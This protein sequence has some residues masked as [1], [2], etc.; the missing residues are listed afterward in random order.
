MAIRNSG[1]TKKSGQDN[2]TVS[3][4]MTA[5]FFGHYIRHY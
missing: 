3:V 1:C 4:L 5:I 2:E